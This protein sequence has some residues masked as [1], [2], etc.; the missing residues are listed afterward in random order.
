MKVR[1][2]AFLSHRL[3]AVEVMAEVVDDEDTRLM[4]NSKFKF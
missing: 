4:S 2:T 1:A 3:D